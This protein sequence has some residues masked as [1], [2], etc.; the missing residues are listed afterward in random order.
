VKSLRICCEYEQY[1]THEVAWISIHLIV[2]K[3]R[4]Y[5]DVKMVEFRTF[6]R[7]LV[8][9]RVEDHDELFACHLLA[10]AVA[11]LN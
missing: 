6:M 1:V 7:A 3:M 8:E 2:L 9:E 4:R 5:E 11:L 10:V